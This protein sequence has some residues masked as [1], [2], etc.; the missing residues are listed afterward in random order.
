[1]E[2]DDSEAVAA[3][4]KGGYGF[5]EMMVVGVTDESEERGALADSLDF[6]EDERAFEVGIGWP[7]SMVTIVEDKGDEE[8]GVGEVAVDEEVGAED[9]GACDSASTFAKDAV[10]VSGSC[11]TAAP[12]SSNTDAM[13]GRG[14]EGVRVVIVCFAC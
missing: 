4:V 1:L 2:N 12:E 14:D 13:D 3:G 7:L 11:L 10:A 6:S 9:E 8:S 5:G